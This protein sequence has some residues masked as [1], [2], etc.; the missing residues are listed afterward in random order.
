MKIATRT[1]LSLIT[2]TEKILEKVRAWQACEYVHPLTCGHGCHT[3]LEPVVQDNG[4]ILVCPDC[5]Y[6]QDWIPTVVLEDGILEKMDPANF[7]GDRWNVFES[8]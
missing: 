8:V 7:L 2:G 6:T 3:N 5:D 1:E 4:V